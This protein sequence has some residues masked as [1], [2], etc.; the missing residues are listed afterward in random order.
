MAFIEIKNLKTTFITEDG[1]VNAVCGADLSIERGERLA[2]IGETGCGKT[3]LGLSIIRLLPENARIDGEI[4]F[5]GKNLL[6]CT[7]EEL[8]QT[9]GKEIMMIFQNP[10]SS[11]NP[12]LTVEKQLCEILMFHQ[13]L[14]MKQSREKA[15]EVLE[16]CELKD[17]GT[18]L[19]RYPYE[20]SGGMR[21]RVMIAMG[22]ISKPS[23]LIA[24]EPSKGLDTKVQKQIYSLLDG[25]SHEFNIALLLITHNLDMARAVC[26][27]IAVM[28]AGEIIEYCPAEKFSH[29]SHPYT[30]GLL[31]AL[32][33]NGMIPIE[34]NS[35]SIIDLPNGCRFH[36]RCSRARKECE[37]ER[38]KMS[39]VGKEHF[40]RCIYG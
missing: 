3:I 34:G 27:R 31:N 32:P 11:L 38:P 9:R 15:K 37:N 24:D 30:R 17:A 40:V 7:E 22:I 5:N 36:P 4:L 2:L 26:D 23:F 21:Q 20:L 16:I 39:E 6:K 13:K 29:A 10:L 12:V 25:I 35:P 1:E 18:I 33:E 19:K 28:Y 14:S 8:R